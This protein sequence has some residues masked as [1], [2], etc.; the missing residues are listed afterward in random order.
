VKSVRKDRIRNDDIKNGGR[1]KY[2]WKNGKE[3]LTHLRKIMG[4][5]EHKEPRGI[6]NWIPPGNGRRCRRKQWK[7]K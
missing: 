1:C 7:E 3:K 6:N 5:E 4:M 2:N